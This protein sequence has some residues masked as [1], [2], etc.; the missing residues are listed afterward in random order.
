VDGIDSVLTKS[1]R[2]VHLPSSGSLQ[3]VPDLLLQLVPVLALG[4]G[5]YDVTVCSSSN[6]W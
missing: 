2:E 3:L 1:L 6:P 4:E 5:L